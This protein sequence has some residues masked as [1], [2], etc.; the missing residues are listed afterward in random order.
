LTHL[1]RDASFG[2]FGTVVVI[3]RCFEETYGGLSGTIV[4]GAHKKRNAPPHR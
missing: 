2:Q 4:V 3:A 1:S